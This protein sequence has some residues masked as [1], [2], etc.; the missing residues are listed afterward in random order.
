MAKDLLVLDS[1]LLRGKC[2]QYRLNRE[3]HCDYARTPETAFEH[4]R[5][6]LRIGGNYEAIVLPAH[7]MRFAHGIESIFSTYGPSE[8]SGPRFVVMTGAQSK[9]SD[10]SEV[11]QGRRVIEVSGPGEASRVALGR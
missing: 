7:Q 9:K 6:K 1:N 2:L 10:V 5:E 4:I 8:G 11:K 3:A